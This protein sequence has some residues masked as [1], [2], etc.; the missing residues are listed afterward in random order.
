MASAMRASS[1]SISGVRKAQALFTLLRL[2]PLIPIDASRRAY[3]ATRR[4]VVADVAVVEEDAAAGVA[5]L[6]GAIGVIPLVD[7]ADG[8]GGRFEVGHDLALFSDLLQQ[9]EDPIKLALLA[10]TGDDPEMVAVLIEPRYF[11][12]L[13]GKALWPL[14]LREQTMQLIGSTKHKGICIRQ[15][16]TCFKVRAE[17]TAQTACQFGRRV[18]AYGRGASLHNPAR[19][20]LILADSRGFRDAAVTKPSGGTILCLCY[21]AHSAEKSKGTRR[22]RNVPHLRRPL[23]FK[24]SRTYWFTPLAR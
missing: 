14:P 21:A 20:R 10:A 22:Q 5:A 15:R 11:E 19:Q 1:R 8:R 18:A 24:C 3:S 17:H 2:Q 13:G 23:E 16:R 12:G 9:V 4:E 6:D 7:P